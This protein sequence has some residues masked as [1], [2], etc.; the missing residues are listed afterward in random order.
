MDLASAIEHTLL[1]AEATPEAIERLCREATAHHF[2]GV[3]VNPVF[4]RRAVSTLLGSSVR[5]VTVVGFPL[6]ASAPEALAF[7]AR[8][9]IEHGAHEVDMVIPIGLALAGSWRDVTAHVSKVRAATTGSVLKVILET[10]HFDEAALHRCAEAVLEA[11][12]DFLKTSTGFGPRGASIRDIEIFKTLCPPSV[13]IKASGG[14]RTRAAALAMLEAGATRI[15]TSNGVA[16][17]T[18]HS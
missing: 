18:G 4:V 11:A 10:G 13:G 2:Q 7:E 9:A 15:G 16:I 1:R 8:T 6:G 3:C 14:I 5:V 17:V 12:P